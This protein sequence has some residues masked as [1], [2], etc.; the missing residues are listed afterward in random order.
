MGGISL[1]KID[2]MSGLSFENGLRLHFDSILLFRNQSYPSAYFLS[3]LAV[4]EI[5]KAFLLED[6]L[7]HSIVDGR[8]EQESEARFLDR[9]FS[10]RFKQSSFARH[11]EVMGRSSFFRS[12][13]G[14][15]LETLKQ[16]SVYVGL[17]RHRKSIDL[18]GRINNPLKV[19]QVKAQKQITDVNDCLLDFTLGVIKQVYIVDSPSVEDSLNERLLSQ[20]RSQWSLIGRRTRARL[21]LLEMVQ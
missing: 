21:K 6:F 18:K 8:M 12:L 14:G 7:W 5:G 3:V 11:L 19:G 16:R 17:P 4:E 13:Y 15:E 9:V 1:V 20:L 2:K 10:H